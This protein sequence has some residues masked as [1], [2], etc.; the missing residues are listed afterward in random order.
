[1]T[2]HYHVIVWIDHSKARVFHVG[3]EDA[4]REVI[5]THSHDRHQ[6]HK[7]N[8]TGS[9]HAP[10]DNEFFGRVTQSIQAAGALL[11]V[12]PANAKTE[13]AAYIRSHS[14]E[15]ARRIS[16]VEAL[17]H[18]SDGQLVALARKFFRADDRMR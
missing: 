10:I 16:A 1:M 17:D 18:P 14:P 4:Q 13:L 9:G 8:S 11:I 6:H 2:E 3:G 15:L 7:A 12:G 5:S